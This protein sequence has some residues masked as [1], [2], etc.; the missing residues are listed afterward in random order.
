MVSREAQSGEH[1]HTWPP[2]GGGGKSG[3]GWLSVASAPKFVAL[4]AVKGSSIWCCVN[5]YISNRQTERLRVNTGKRFGLVLPWAQ[6]VLYWSRRR[7]TGHS[8]TTHEWQKAHLCECWELPQ[9]WFFLLCWHWSFLCRLLHIRA[10]AHNSTFNFPALEWA[11]FP[12]AIV[13]PRRIWNL[14]RSASTAQI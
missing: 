4:L 2:V 10:T 6:M 9:H 3:A 12:R 14:S 1:L 11:R 8:V 7:Q 5:A 13:F